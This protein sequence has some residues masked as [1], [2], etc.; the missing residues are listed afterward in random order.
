MWHCW[1]EGYRCYCYFSVAPVL[2]GSA[3]RL[4]DSAGGMLGQLHVSGSWSHDSHMTATHHLTC[5]LVSSNS[6]A[7]SIEY[8]AKLT[9]VYAHDSSG[10]LLGDRHGYSILWLHT[11]LPDTVVFPWKHM[12][13]TQKCSVR[14]ILYLGYIVLCCWLVLGGTCR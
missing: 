3:A 12:C 6:Y 10:G 14:S 7:Y 5:I 8:G 1:G 11:V 4:K 9:S 13:C 2:C